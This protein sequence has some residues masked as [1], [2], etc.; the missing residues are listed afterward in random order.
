MTDAY[1]WFGVPAAQ[2]LLHN[3]KEAAVERELF[4]RFFTEAY[5]PL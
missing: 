4:E 2:A 1:T 3:P 5:V